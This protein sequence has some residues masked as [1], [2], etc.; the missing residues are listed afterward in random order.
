MG[1][2]GRLGLWRLRHN[3]A[4]GDHS[5]FMGSR[6]RWGASGLTALRAPDPARSA[7]F[8]STVRCYPRGAVPTRTRLLCMAEATVLRR[9]IE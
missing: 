4:S 6:P 5:E 2:A 9:I 3:T 8:F 1:T 7:S